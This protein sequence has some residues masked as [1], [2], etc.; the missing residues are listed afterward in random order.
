MALTTG[1]DKDEEDTKVERVAERLETRFPDVDPAHVVEIVEEE[2][3]KFEGRPVRDFVPVL[4]EHEA[5]ERLEAE[6]DVEIHDAEPE[7]D[8]PETE[9][10]FEMESIEDRHRG[11][12]L[13]GAD[14][15]RITAAEYGALGTGSTID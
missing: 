11:E 9:G 10:E 15:A 12:K 3:E 8:Q 14:A 2:H 4:V 13:T 7:D 5:R 6:G 1:M